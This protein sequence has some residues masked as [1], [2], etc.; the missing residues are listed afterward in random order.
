MR[1]LAFAV[2]LLVPLV[3]SAHADGPCAEKT[4]GVGEDPRHSVTIHDDCT[5]DVVL[6]DGIICL[7]GGVGRTDT[8]VGPVHVTQYYC[9]YPGF[10][11]HLFDLEDPGPTDVFL[12]QLMGCTWTGSYKPLV[13]VGPVTV[14]HYTCDP[15]T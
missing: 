12:P 2:L 3:P 13:T 6:N 7:G 14:W 11:P 1:A 9:T 5:I 15:E 4:F 10:P 8:D